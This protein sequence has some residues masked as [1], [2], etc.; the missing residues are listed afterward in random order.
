M[1]QFYKNLNRQTLEIQVADTANWINVSPPF[2][3]QEIDDLSE[4]LAIPHDF[5]MDTIDIE[6]R[7]CYEHEDGV[8]LIIIKTPVENK[9]L[10]ESDAFFI[11]IPIA[12]IITERSQ[13]VTVN[14][15]EN[16]AIRRFL[17]TFAK[18]HPERPN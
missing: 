10:N 12:V 8:R 16:V 2:Q 11:T 9:S 14:S 6:E 18:R 7:A 15:F 17:G 13:V 5:L 1:I 3:Q 4:K